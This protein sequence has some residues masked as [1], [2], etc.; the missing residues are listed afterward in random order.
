MRFDTCRQASPDTCDGPRGRCV[1]T[2][3][4]CTLEATPAELYFRVCCILAVSLRIHTDRVEARLVVSLMAECAVTG[5]AKRSKRRLQATRPDRS[6]E[7]ETRPIL[8]QLHISA[9]PGD[10][11]ERCNCYAIAA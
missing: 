2:H 1:I 8:A 11:R 4:L 3:T 6:L 5:F 7:L 9:R 10:L